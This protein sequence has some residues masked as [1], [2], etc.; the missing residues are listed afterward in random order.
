M[1]D[2]SLAGYIFPR[3]RLMKYLCINL[4]LIR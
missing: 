3:L 4:W 1:V 2:T